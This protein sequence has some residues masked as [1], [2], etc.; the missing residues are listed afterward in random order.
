MSEK[1]TVYV[2]STCPYCTMMTNYLDEIHVPYETINVST[3]PEEG[4]RLMEITG[5]MGVP[6]TQLNGKWIIGFDPA[7]IQAALDA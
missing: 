5:Q 4:E 1:A 2:S 3:N 6:Q 7:S